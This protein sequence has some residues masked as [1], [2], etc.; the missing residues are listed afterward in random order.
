[1]GQ[2]GGH[3]S[4]RP[5]SLLGGLDE[6]TTIRLFNIGTANDGADG[7]VDIY[8]RG[9]GDETVNHPHTTATPFDGTWHHVLFV[10][11]GSTAKVYVDGVL[12]AIELNTGDNPLPV[13]TVSIGGIRRAAASHFV[14]GLIDDVKLWDQALSAD[15]RGG[16]GCSSCCRWWRAQHRLRFLPRHGWAPSED[17]AAADPPLTEAAD[18][19][20]TNL[21]TANGHTVTRVLSQDDPLG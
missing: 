2:R 10:Q 12:D 21:L 3:G 7:S 18:I 5:A 4:E 6:Q 20:Y 15:P 1:M 8:I 17:A 19:G 9:G 14:T 13:D 16:G 11:D